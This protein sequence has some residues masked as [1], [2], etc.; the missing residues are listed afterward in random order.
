MMKAT[1]TQQGELSSP[2]PSSLLDE[3]DDLIAKHKRTIRQSRSQLHEA[4]RQ[5]ADLLEKLESFGIGY[6]E[7]TQIQPQGAED[8]HGQDT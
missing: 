8:S 2:L 1:Q 5:R 7:E 4:A 3:L 6:A